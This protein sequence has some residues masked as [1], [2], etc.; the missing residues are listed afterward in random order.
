MY[1]SQKRVPHTTHSRHR[2]SP[3]AVDGSPYKDYDVQATH[4]GGPY[5]NK[6]FRVGTQLLT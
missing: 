5:W 4:D 2:W 6:D 1:G 3:L